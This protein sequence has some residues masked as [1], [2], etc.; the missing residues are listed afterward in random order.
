M[1][2]RSARTGGIT[3]EEPQEV[4]ELAAF[5]EDEVA[6]EQRGEHGEDVGKRV[7]R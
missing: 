2:L 1:R 4:V 7:L 5:I 3:E 6:A